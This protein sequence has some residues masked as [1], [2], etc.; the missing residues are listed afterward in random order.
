MSPDLGYTWTKPRPVRRTI[1]V[2]IV[3]DDRDQVLSLMMILRQEGY[4]ARGAYDGFRALRELKEFEPDAVL[5]DIA[6]PGMSGWD[7]A[8]EIRKRDREKPKLIA[9]TGMYVKKPDELLSRVV[10]FDHYLLKPCDPQFL[11]SVLGAL[12]AGNSN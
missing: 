3:D 8:R 6:M 5:V 11:L 2:L 4:E 9:I 1:R 12:V 10:G 7:I